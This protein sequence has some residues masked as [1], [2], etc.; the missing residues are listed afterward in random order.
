M[1]KKDLSDIIPDLKMGELRQLMSEWHDT[2]S[3]IEALM[4]RDIGDL[5]AAND[6]EVDKQLEAIGLE[7]IS[8]VKRIASETADSKEAIIAKLLVW[9]DLVGPTPQNDDWIQPSDKIVYSVL[10]DLSA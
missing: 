9:A 8:L 5:P 6:R 7:Q 3:D 2:Q 10:E 4:N 1:Q